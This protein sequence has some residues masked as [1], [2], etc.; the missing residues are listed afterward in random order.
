MRFQSSLVQKKSW[1]RESETRINYWQV[2]R[3]A[4]CGLAAFEDASKEIWILSCMQTCSS[5][6]WKPFSP[7]RSTAAFARISARNRNDSSRGERL[8]RFRGSS[9][10]E[11]YSRT[12]RGNKHLK[13][14]F[15]RDKNYSIYVKFDLKW[16]SVSLTHSLSL[17]ARRVGY[18]MGRDSLSVPSVP[19]ARDARQHGYSLGDIND[20]FKLIFPVFFLLGR[21]ELVASPRAASLDARRMGRGEKKYSSQPQKKRKS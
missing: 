11:N 9:A 5:I 18:P 21:P 13:V 6:T 2:F 15:N 16:L 19:P 1:N 14:D 20:S 10:R 7:T 4:F 12:R 3:S 8:K 17:R